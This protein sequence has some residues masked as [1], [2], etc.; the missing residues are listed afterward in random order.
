MRRICILTP[1]PSY[2]E[3]WAPMADHFR[4]LFGPTL[5]FRPWTASGDLTDFDLILPLLAWGYQ[6]DPALWYQTLDRWDAEH[7]P[8][9]NPCAL[10][11]WN[12][13][14]AYCSILRQRA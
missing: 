6:R 14:K 13:D 12:T 2:P 3:N 4:M 9:A 10:L 7:L 8:V 1:D 5:D 11:R